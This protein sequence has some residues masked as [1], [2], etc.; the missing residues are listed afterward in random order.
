MCLMTLILDADSLI[1]LN[2]VGAL[3]LVAISCNCVIPDAVYQEAVVNARAAG[4]LDSEAIDQIVGLYVRIESAVETGQQDIPRQFGAGEKQ[5]LSLA[6]R[7]PQFSVVVSDDQAFVNLLRQ[8]EIR[9]ISPIEL[10]PVLLRWGA[11]SITQAREFLGLFRPH[12][13]ERNY[14]AAVSSLNNSE[15]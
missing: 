15:Q 12:T 1:K 5:V 7:N 2:R 9:F 6:M 14:A 8:L 11:I 13:T 4:Y 3:E 10:F